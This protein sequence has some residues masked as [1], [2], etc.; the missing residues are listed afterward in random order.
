[1]S[2]EQIEWRYVWKE[3]V[4]AGQ[5]SL[6]LDDEKLERFFPVLINL[7]GDDKMIL[8]EKAITL[9]CL[10]NKTEAEKLYKQSADEST[11]LPVGHWRKRAQ[12][13]LDR[14]SCKN[15]FE[16]YIWHWGGAICFFTF[17]GCYYGENSIK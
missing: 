7:Y 4:D 8:F 12:Y 2:E 15:H 3:C 9:E 16:N 5:K 11:G 10:G 1:M 14:N 17:G 6:L 13:Y